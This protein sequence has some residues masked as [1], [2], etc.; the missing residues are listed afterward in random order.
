MGLEV[1]TGN[2]RPHS[3]KVFCYALVLTLPLGLA[4]CQSEAP[5]TQK[6]TQPADNGAP[7]NAIHVTGTLYMV[8]IGDDKGPCTLYRALNTDGVAIAAIHYRKA[9]GSFVMDKTRSDC[10]K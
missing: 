5:M 10:D 2:L 4:A 9:D 1:L 8:P 7:A 3:L 6:T